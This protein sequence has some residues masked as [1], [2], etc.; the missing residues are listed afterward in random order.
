ML[1][2]TYYGLINCDEFTFDFHF[3]LTMNHNQHND[4]VLF[5]DDHMRVRVGVNNAT[6]QVNLY[7]LSKIVMYIKL[8]YI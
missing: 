3:I 6:R 4:K 8:M 2:I 1:C 5:V 7:V